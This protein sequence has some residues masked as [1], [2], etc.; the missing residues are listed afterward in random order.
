MQLRQKIAT[1]QSTLRHPDKGMHEVTNSTTTDDDVRAPTSQSYS[2]ARAGW[3][4]RRIAI[5][6]CECKG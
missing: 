5:L 6:C 2:G 4:P 3:P 1:E